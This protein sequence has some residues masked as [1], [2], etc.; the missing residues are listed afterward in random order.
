MKVRLPVGAVRES[1]LQN[2]MRREGEYKIRPYVLACG[3][4]VGAVCETASTRRDPTPPP[5]LLI[6]LPT[7]GRMA[8][9]V[10]ERKSLLLGGA[11]P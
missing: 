4:P 6:G 1:P 3:D 5:P 11:G 7:G 9:A 8:A 2:V 10:R